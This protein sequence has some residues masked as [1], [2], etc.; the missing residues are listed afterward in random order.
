MRVFGVPTL[1]SNMCTRHINSHKLVSDK[2]PLHFKG[3][4]R[5]LSTLHRTTNTTSH[6]KMPSMQS[7]ICSYLQL[8]V[9]MYVYPSTAIRTMFS[10]LFMLAQVIGTNISWRIICEHLAAA[11]AF[12]SVHAGMHAFVCCPAYAI[13]I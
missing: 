11:C 10:S 4:R 6:T 12:R 2:K 1:H 9:I 8:Y 3:I 7:A 13:S 5:S